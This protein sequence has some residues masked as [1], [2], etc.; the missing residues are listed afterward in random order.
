MCLGVISYQPLDGGL[1]LLKQ[2]VN[3]QLTIPV[4]LIY[5]LYCLTTK[6]TRIVLNKG[7]YRTI[8]M[9]ICQEYYC[10]ITNP[11][12][13]LG[14]LIVLSRLSLYPPSNITSTLT[15]F[16]VLEIGDFPDNGS[17]ALN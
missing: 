12:T 4:F 17:G 2:I 13:G 5:K 3:E 10:C 16:E 8:F 9:L 7:D 14:K 15:T 1:M 6:K 11:E